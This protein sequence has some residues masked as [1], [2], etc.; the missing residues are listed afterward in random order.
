[1]TKQQEQQIARIKYEAKH[2]MGKHSDD[3]EIK[4]FEVE[5]NKFFVSINVEV[6]A[7]NDEGTLAAIFCRDNTLIFIG[8]RGGLKVPCFKNNKM[9]YKPYKCFIGA[10]LDYNKR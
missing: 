1:M 6:G 7:K 9:Y 5:E 8:R 10:C 4:K 3:Y 2:Y